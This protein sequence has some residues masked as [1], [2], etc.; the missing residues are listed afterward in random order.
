[1]T[2]DVPPEIPTLEN[3]L[4]F[5]TLERDHFE[6]RFVS[7]RRVIREQNVVAVRQ[8]LRPPVAELSFFLIRNGKRRRISS[9]RRDSAQSHVVVLDV[10]DYVVTDPRH[11]R[12]IR[13]RDRC[14][15]PTFYVSLPNFPVR[16]ESDPFAI[17]RKD[18]G[19]TH[20]CCA[21]NGF[22]CVFIQSSQEELRSASNKSAEGERLSIV[23]DSKD[24]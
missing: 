17:V 18:R 20:A 13:F 23:A 2:S 21:L 8:Q 1:M 7:G 4:A 10:D 3:D 22:C 24:L 11:L 5:S 19:S 9:F 12:P 16:V 6:L 14:R 15:R